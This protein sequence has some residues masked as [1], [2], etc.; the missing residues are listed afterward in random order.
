MEKINLSEILKHCPEGMKLWTDL[1]GEVELAGGD[2]GLYYPIAIKTNVYNYNI[3]ITATGAYL[4]DSNQDD[5]FPCILWPDSGR[6]WDSW[7]EKIMPK[8][9]GKVI[10]DAGGF[11][12]IVGVGIFVDVNGSEIEECDFNFTGARFANNTEIEDFVKILG[13]VRSPSVVMRYS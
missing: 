7:Q 3:G 9:Y 5:I 11:F 4:T 6:T 8:C 13:A 2:V 10:V 12:Y 1:Y